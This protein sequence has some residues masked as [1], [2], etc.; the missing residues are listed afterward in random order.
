MRKKGEEW[1]GKAKNEKKRRRMRRKGAITLET[2]D[3]LKSKTFDL[4][5]YLA[6]SM[7]Y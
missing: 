3:D 2:D 5:N 1:E 7:Y 6:L 4:L